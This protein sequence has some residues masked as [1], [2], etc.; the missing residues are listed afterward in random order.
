MTNFV[1]DINEKSLLEN[2]AFT[3][4]SCEESDSHLHTQARIRP[5]SNDRGRSN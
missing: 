2:K 4:T 1:K 3:Q 5:S